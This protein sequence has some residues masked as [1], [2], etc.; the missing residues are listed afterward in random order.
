[1]KLGNTKLLSIEEFEAL[2][3]AKAKE[4]GTRKNVIYYSQHWLLYVQNF[5]E[6]FFIHHLGLNNSDDFVDFGYKKDLDN[7]GRT[8]KSS[9]VLNSLIFVG[10]NHTLSYEAGLIKDAYNFSLDL[11]E[12]HSKDN[13]IIK[14]D[15]ITKYK[16]K[17]EEFGFK[18]QMILPDEIT[19]IKLSTIRDNFHFDEKEFKY[20]KKALDDNL[21][22]SIMYEMGGFYK[23]Y[24]KYMSNIT[25]Q[26][27]NV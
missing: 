25:K 15:I 16:D 1:M 5:I 21:D 19:A 20:I 24:K 8:I 12:K 7:I 17:A 2:W 4:L 13:R 11:Y 6:Y 14:N 22:S 26:D 9:D 23:A 27:P 3:K 18:I 10:A